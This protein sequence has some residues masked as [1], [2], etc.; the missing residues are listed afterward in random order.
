VRASGR[1]LVARLAAEGRPV[2][3]V[4]SGLAVAA[5]PLAEELGAADLLGNALDYRDGVATGRIEPRRGGWV[6]AYAAAHGVDLGRSA[7]YGS[8]L[9]D[10]PLLRAVGSPCAVNPDARLRT[11]ADREGWPV[12]TLDAARA[13]PP[14]VPN[15]AAR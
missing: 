3:L 6:E 7:A 12:L 13:E 8:D 9:E 14:R 15:P 10:E 4:T 1:D 11:L 5:A 2:V